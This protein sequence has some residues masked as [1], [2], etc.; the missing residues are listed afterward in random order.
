[1]N[2]REDL[3]LTEMAF[4]TIELLFVIAIVSI[5]T[6]SVMYILIAGIRGPA[7]GYQYANSILAVCLKE[8]DSNPDKYLGLNDEQ[9]AD[10]L[11]DTLIDYNILKP[12]RKPFGCVDYCPEFSIEVNQTDVPSAPSFKRVI[13]RVGWHERGRDRFVEGFVIM[14][15]I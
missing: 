15:K 11:T 14:G 5:A 8:L 2:L 6:V 4:S 7:K 1:M 13:V 3:K 9:L 10:E 12:S